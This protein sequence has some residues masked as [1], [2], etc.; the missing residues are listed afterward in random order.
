MIDIVSVAF[1]CILNATLARLKKM[2]SNYYFCYLMVVVSNTYS[3]TSPKLGGIIVST[4]LM[5]TGKSSSRIVRNA[6]SNL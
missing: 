1:D 6:A 4:Q 2:S 3:F 5:L